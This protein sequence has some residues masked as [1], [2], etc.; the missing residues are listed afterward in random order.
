VGLRLEQTAMDL[1][2]VTGG[3]TDTNDYFRAYPTLH[4]G[5]QISESQQVKAS[6]SKRVQRPGPQQLN[7]FRFYQ[8]P[9]NV[10]SGN[11][12]LE[13]QETDSFELTWLYR[14]G[15]TF[16]QATAYY[17]D[18]SEAF[19]DVVID[20]GG[21]VF[22]TRPENLGSSRLA[23]VEL[24][25]NG[26]LH[27]T[28][29]YNASLNLYRQEIDASNLGF[30]QAQ[31]GST[32][33]ASLGLNWQPTPEDFI[34][35]NGFWNGETLLPQ[36][37]REPGGMLNL[38]Y[39]RKLNDK[40]SFVGTVRDVFDNFGDEFAFDTPQFNERTERDFGGRVVYIGLTYTFGARQQQQQPPQFDFSSGSPPSG[41]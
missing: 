18:T 10:R 30:T 4:L 41:G 27:P 40:L 24:V 15:P 9:L 8:D 6:Y 2:Q 16:Y 3:I 26:R 20:I 38:G 19:T 13:P 23:G 35:I 39:R 1:I 22:L 36:G 32:F 7:P 17:R 12:Q 29:R 33:R 37:V 34:Q 5:Y 28:L 21:G 14:S 11:A 25:A 31:E